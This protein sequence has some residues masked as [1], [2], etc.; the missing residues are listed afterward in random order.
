MPEPR[1]QQFHRR[2]RVRAVPSA[3]CGVEKAMGF[4]PCCP[5]EVWGVA[6]ASVGGPSSALVEQVGI[7][8]G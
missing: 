4:S 7:L 5:E 6:Q 8:A 1:T 3:C 2:P